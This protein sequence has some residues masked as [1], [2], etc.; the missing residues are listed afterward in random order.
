MLTSCLHNI[1]YHTSR[2]KKL[3]ELHLNGQKATLRPVI[4]YQA[5]YKYEFSF[6]S[7]LKGQG[8]GPSAA[9]PFGLFKGSPAF[10]FMQHFLQSPEFHCNATHIFSQ[11]V[12]LL[13]VGYTDK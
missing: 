4:F 2:F 1:L 10:P 5:Q 8:R 6:F 9:G 3:A 13:S 7:H 11:P 12:P